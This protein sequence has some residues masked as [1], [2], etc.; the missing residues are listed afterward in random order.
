VPAPME[1]LNHRL[2]ALIAVLTIG[3]IGLAAMD[4]RHA[5]AS[6]VKVVADMVHQLVSTIRESDIAQVEYKIEDIEDQIGRAES[7]SEAARPNG[8]GQ[9]IKDLK[10]KKERYIRKLER[11][12]Q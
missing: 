2:T 5:S 3:A 6:D 11:L 10:N 4:S 7:V 12:E 8:T 9:H 1:V